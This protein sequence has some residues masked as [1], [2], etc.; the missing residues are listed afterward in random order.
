LKAARSAGYLLVSELLL[1]R[2]A[3]C[4]GRL[5]GLKFSIAG[6]CHAHFSNVLSLSFGINDS[7]AIH[8]SDLSG[9]DFRARPFK[10][11]ALLGQIISLL[12]S[13]ASLTLVSRQFLA[14]GRWP[15]LSLAKAAFIHVVNYFAIFRAEAVVFFTQSQLV[16]K[17]D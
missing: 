13:L 10:L 7:S 9:D 11:L 4:D 8:E 2:P 15:D 16:E 6:G 17:P 5:I 3:T 1:L 14:H 12:G